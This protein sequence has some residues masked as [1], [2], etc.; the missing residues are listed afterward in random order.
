MSQFLP[1]LLH[2]LVRVTLLKHISNPVP[3]P[4]SASLKFGILHDL[5]P[6]YPP[7]PPPICTFKADLFTCLFGAFAQTVLPDLSPTFSSVLTPGLPQLAP[8]PASP[9]LLEFQA[10][11][12]TC[13]MESLQ[14]EV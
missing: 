8:A 9:E 7:V 6:S 3:N 4:S 1:T 2:T 10:P 5:A 11:Q 14:P 12:V 13:S